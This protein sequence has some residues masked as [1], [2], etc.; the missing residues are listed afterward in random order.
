VLATGSPPFSMTESW[1]LLS[2]MASGCQSTLVLAHEQ[3]L[4][5]AIK[6]HILARGSDQ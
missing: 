3:Q 2:A 4:R 1:W 5:A 6:M